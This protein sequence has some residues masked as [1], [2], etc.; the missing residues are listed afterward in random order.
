MKLIK[1]LELYLKYE[2]NLIIKKYMNNFNQKNAFM[3]FLAFR[4]S[5]SQR[6]K[7]C[8]DLIYILNFE[9]FEI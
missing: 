7:D 5:A 8:T 2:D 4:S 3:Y 9:F 1:A 6:F